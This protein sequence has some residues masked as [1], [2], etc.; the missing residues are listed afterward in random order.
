MADPTA[1][2]PDSEES[3]VSFTPGPWGFVGRNIYDGRQVRI[4]WAAWPGVGGKAVGERNARL[5]AAA[6]NLLQAL[7]ELLTASELE[8]ADS[9]RFFDA[10]N[11][12]LA[13]IAKAEGR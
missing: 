8:G 7:R 6:P 3:A 5:M 2:K 9:A 12:G 1:S 10:R 4:G 11:A 13:A